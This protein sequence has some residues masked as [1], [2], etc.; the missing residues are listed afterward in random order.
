[1]ASRRGMGGHG[2]DVLLKRKP[3]AEAGLQTADRIG[4][5]AQLIRV[6]FAVPGFGRP[7]ARDRPSD[8]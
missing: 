1:L 5:S 6:C 7:N 2:L 3:I 8:L 4:N